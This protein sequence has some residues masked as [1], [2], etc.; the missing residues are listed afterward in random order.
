MRKQPKQLQCDVQ[1]LEG[2]ASPSRMHRSAQMHARRLQRN[3]VDLLVKE[4]IKKQENICI[5]FR[6]RRNDFHCQNETT[7][8]PTA[9]QGSYK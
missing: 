3:Q 9:R 2:T 4:Q 7:K 6:Q 5:G 1:R 8:R